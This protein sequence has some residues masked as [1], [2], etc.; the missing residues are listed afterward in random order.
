MKL[1]RKHIGEKV[2]LK[3]SLLSEDYVILIGIRDNGEVN[4]LRFDPNHKVKNDGKVIE[5]GRDIGDNYDYFGYAADNEDW[6]LVN[7]NEP[8][9]YGVFGCNEMHVER[10]VKYLDKRYAH[11]KEK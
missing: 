10:L 7:E 4:Y 9:N 3:Y 11:Q 1:T 6:E 8:Y 2:R 5:S